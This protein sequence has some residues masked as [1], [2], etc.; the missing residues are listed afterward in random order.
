MTSYMYSSNEN[1]YPCVIRSVSYSDESR[2]GSSYSGSSSSSSGSSS[3]GSPKSESYD[4]NKS[5]SID[6]NITDLSYNFS[7]VIS[8]SGSSS[9]SDSSIIPPSIVVPKLFLY[10]LNDEDIVIARKKRGCCH[11]AYMWCLCN[12]EYYKLIY[13]GT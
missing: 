4:S 6:S 7:D 13:F 1:Q 2:S 3:S 5:S 11:Y 8:S 10:D 9:S 12:V